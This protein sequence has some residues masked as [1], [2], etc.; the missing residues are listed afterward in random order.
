MDKK[1]RLIAAGAVDRNA[2]S[3]RPPRVRREPTRLRQQIAEMLDREAIRQLAIAYAR[4]AR[5]RDVGGIVGLYAKDAVFDALRPA[6]W[7]SIHGHCFEMLASN[8]AEGSVYIELGKGGE[9]H[10]ASHI[11]CFRDDYVKEEGV[12]K[13][14]SRRLYS[15]P[16]PMPGVGPE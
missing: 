7:P 13:F 12:W 8:R 6:P 3:A 16:L 14:R 1:R 15:V 9:G 11:A 5:T 4:F 10:R 2:A